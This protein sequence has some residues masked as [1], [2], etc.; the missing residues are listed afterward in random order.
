MPANLPPQYH[1]IEKKYR[2]A[3]NASDKLTFL[4]EML[5]VIPKHKGTE[6]LQGD[7]KRRISKLQNQVQK[8]RKA[9]RKPYGFSVQREGAAQLVLLGPPSSGKSSILKALTRAE[10]EIADYPFTT[11]RPLPGMMHYEDIQIQLIDL[12]PVIEGALEHWFLQLVANSDGTLIILDVSSPSVLEELDTVREQ[13]ALHRIFLGEVPDSDEATDGGQVSTKRFLV[14]GNKADL[15]PS[16]ET[17]E[18]LAESLGESA[19]L[20]LF[21]AA[22]D[23]AVGTLKQGIFQMVEL[24]RVYTKIPGKKP[25]MG[26]PFVLPRGSTVLDV[27]ALVHKD[28][29]ANL[30][31]ARIWGS[32]AFDGQYVQRDHVVADKD[33]IELHL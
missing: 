20:I 7:L 15:K 11:R 31:A 1:E 25:D 2:E 21:S 19:R 6:K 26:K 18:L 28:F 30:K 4:R 5:S 27:A 24:V 14:I 32:G 22:D 8:S 17:I 29:F 33:V 9:S 10:P 3:R 13:L 23:D 16:P 12:P